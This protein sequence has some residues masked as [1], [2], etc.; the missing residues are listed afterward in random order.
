MVPKSAIERLKEMPNKKLASHEVLGCPN[1]YGLI[2]FCDKEIMQCERY[3]DTQ[4]CVK[5]WTKK[6]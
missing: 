6:F 4:Q 1:D 3:Q 5:C 2:G